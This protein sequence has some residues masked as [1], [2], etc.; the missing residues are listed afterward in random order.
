MR[1]INFRLTKRDKKLIDAC[2]NF[3]NYVWMVSQHIYEDIVSLVNIGYDNV[4][5]FLVPFNDLYKEAA[6]IYAN[7]Y[8]KKYEDGLNKLFE[9]RRDVVDFSQGDL[10]RDVLDDTKLQYEDKVGI[11]LKG[12][13]AVL[14]MMLNAPKENVAPDAEEPEHNYKKPDPKDKAKK[15]NQMM[16]AHSPYKAYG[17]IL[18]SLVPP[19]ATSKGGGSGSS[20]DKSLN[21][22]DYK[23]HQ[24]LKQKIAQLAR[25]IYRRGKYNIFD[26]ARNFFWSYDR[27]DKGKHKDVVAGSSVRYRKMNSLADVFKL[28]QR[29]YALPED[30]FLQKVMNKDFLVKQYQ[31]RHRKKQLIY[32]LADCSGSMEYERRELF[33]KSLMLSLARKSLEDGGYMYF[34]FF[35]GSPF[36]MRKIEKRYQWLDFTQRVL[37]RRMSGGTDI[38]AVLSQACNDIKNIKEVVDETEIVLITDGTERLHPGEIRERVGKNTKSH[39]VLLENSSS[40]A[41]YAEAFDSVLVSKVTSVEE[42][43]S[44]GLEFTKQIA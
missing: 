42:A 7:Q 30:V 43:L 23:L 15:A 1:M 13:E 32:V 8:E 35:S 24:E 28:Q 6:N 18:D 17:N 4:S 26:L 22:Q 44:K 41:N 37:G 10:F 25:S 16:K 2:T 40:A 20:R 38:H 39:C 36:P 5:R 33:M 14:D 34:R 31:E 29:A 19:K 12:M 27:H 3:G 11:L 21:E 9:M